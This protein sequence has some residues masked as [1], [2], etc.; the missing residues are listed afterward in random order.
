MGGRAVPTLGVAQRVLD[1]HAHVRRAKLGLHRT[2]GELDG[3]VDLALAV[4]EH[5][6]VVNR[7]VEEVVRLDDLEALV[8]EGRA[9]Y[10]DL[11][12]HLPRGVRERHGGRDVLEL[13]ARAAEEGAA[14]AGEPDLAHVL[15]TLPHQALVDGVVLGIHRQHATR[16]GH[17][18]EQLAADDEGLL[19]GRRP[20]LAGAQGLG[21]RPDTCL[22]HDGH[23]HHVDVVEAGEP[24]D[25]VLAK[26]KVATLGQLAECRVVL[27]ALVAQGRI[28]HAELTGD[29]DELLGR[30]VGRDGHELDLVWV[31][32][33][34]VER[35]GADG[36][37]ATK[38]RQTRG[39]LALLARASCFKDVHRIPPK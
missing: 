26:A 35:L 20:D 36:A 31:H 8:H 3:G 22:A 17:R 23:K 12:A 2:V 38:K 24:G 5:V 10:G 32:A 7:H 30:R 19:V 4:H 29:G 25:R 28:P 21:A 13:V 11:G 14:R 37:G 18:H 16:L 1:G 39:A 27:T 9:V 33:A 15:A 6:D 34:D